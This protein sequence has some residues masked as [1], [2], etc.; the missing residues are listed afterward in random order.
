[1]APSSLSCGV[2][3]WLL[4]STWNLSALTKDQTHVPCTARGFL[5]TGPPGKSLP[6]CFNRDMLNCGL[7]SFPSNPV[8]FHF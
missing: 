3:T 5:T 4:C 7:I 2:W 1:M 8:I 6:I